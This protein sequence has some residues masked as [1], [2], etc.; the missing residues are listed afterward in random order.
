M[1]RRESGND[2]VAVAAVCQRRPSAVTDRR[3]SWSSAE[4]ADAT[5]ST[6][7]HLTTDYRPPSALFAIGRTRRGELPAP[8]S[9]PSASRYY[10]ELM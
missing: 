4:T 3:Y 9:Q 6:T 8:C 5:S 1:I 7:D 2:L 10:W